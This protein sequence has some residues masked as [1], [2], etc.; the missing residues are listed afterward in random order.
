MNLIND[1]LR[2]INCA[3]IKLRCVSPL[4]THSHPL[5]HLPHPQINKKEKRKKEKNIETER[6][7]SCADMKTDVNR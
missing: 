6:R 7:K 3:L 5:P 1:C 2:L 4:S